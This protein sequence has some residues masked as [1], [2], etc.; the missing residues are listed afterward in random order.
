MKVLQGLQLSP[1]LDTG[2]A[3]HYQSRPSCLEPACLITT[4]GNASCLHQPYLFLVQK[5]DQFFMPLVPKEWSGPEFNYLRH[6][7]QREMK[8][9]PGAH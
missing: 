3:E 9:Y 7:K 6:L 2:S 5:P 8:L 4:M 1:A